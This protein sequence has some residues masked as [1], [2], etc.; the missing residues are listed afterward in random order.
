MCTAGKKPGF[1]L[2]ILQTQPGN[3]R[4]FCFESFA[5]TLSNH[6]TDFDDFFVWSI[7]KK[8]KCTFSYLFE[9]FSRSIES[10]IRVTSGTGKP[11]ILKANLEITGNFLR[12]CYHCRKIYDQFLFNGEAVQKPKKFK[13][14]L[15]RYS[16]TVYFRVNQMTV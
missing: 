15:A 2:V 4:G 5:A 9:L 10:I 16:A 7:I 11:G 12:N 14:C 6:R 3:S 1:F 13:A 8:S